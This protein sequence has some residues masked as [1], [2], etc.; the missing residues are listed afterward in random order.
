MR[1]G[2]LRQPVCAGWIAS[3]VRGLLCTVTLAARHVVRCL[4]FALNASL[5][6]AHSRRETH[7]ECSGRVTVRRL[8]NHMRASSDACSGTRRSVP[9]RGGAVPL[10]RARLARPPTK[11]SA[12]TV[13]VFRQT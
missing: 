8:C 4:Q 9:L 13:G 11:R 2:H 3:P 12:R 5:G 7:T 6:S 10:H 1:R